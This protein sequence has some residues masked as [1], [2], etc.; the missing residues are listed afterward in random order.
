MLIQ[1][2]E[3]YAEC[4]QLGSTD[5]FQRVRRKRAGPQ[6]AS[7]GN[8]PGDSSVEDHRS[9]A[10]AAHKVA[11]R[12][13]VGGAWPSVSVQRD[14]LT[15]KDPRV[16]H[17]YRL[18]LKQEMMMQWRCNQSV[19]LVRPIL[20][21][22]HERYSIPDSGLA[23]CRVG[24]ASPMRRKFLGTVISSFGDTFGGFGSGAA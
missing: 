8:L 14:R 4:M 3:L 1:T 12:E 24:G 9:L 17:S 10:I 20:F 18:I 6:G 22:R 16:E 15:R 19:E 21:V 23:G 11:P 2:L 5:V 13:N 7:L